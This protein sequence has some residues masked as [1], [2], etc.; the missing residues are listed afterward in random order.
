MILSCSASVIRGKHLQLHNLDVR[1]MVASASRLSACPEPENHGLEQAIASDSFG[2]VFHGSSQVA[3]G[4]DTPRTDGR[5]EMVAAVVSLT[6][7]SGSTEPLPILPRYRF[8][9]RRDLPNQPSSDAEKLYCR[10]FAVLFQE[11]ANVGGVRRRPARPGFL[12]LPLHFAAPFGGLDVMRGTRPLP[13]NRI[14]RLLGRYGFWSRGTR[15][16]SKSRPFI[17]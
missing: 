13:C 5:G 14:T 17:V 15:R 9:L 4:R 12:L 2:G 6:V 1:C 8:C 11:P 10:V 7:V 3:D 16:C